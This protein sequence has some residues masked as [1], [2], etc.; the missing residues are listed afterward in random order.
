VSTLNAEPTY[1]VAL[2]AGLPL[3]NAN[4][5]VHWRTRARITKTLREAACV[6]AKQQRIP[7]LSRVEMT[8]VLHPH[9]KR[10]RD[11][12]NWFPS[13]KAA[14]DGIVDAGVLVDDNTRFLAET[15]TVLGPVVRHNQIAVHITEI[16]TES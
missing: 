9:D 4:G 7:R 8:L 2:P 10:P 15:R 1:V 6:V 13:F 11:A 12:H 14:I 3:L 5:R 16:G